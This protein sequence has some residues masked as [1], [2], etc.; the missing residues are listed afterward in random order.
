MGTAGFKGKPNEQN[1]AEIG[2]EINSQSQ[3]MGLATEAVGALIDFAV[4][5]EVNKMFAHT[6]PLEN[7][8]TNVLRKCNFV[9]VKEVVDPEDGNIWQWTFLKR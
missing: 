5:N 6:L 2:Y 4:V 7:A 8:S 3:G 1:G 9:F